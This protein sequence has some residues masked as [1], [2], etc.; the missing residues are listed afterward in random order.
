MNICVL[1]LVTEWHGVT[2]GMEVH[3]RLLTR[4][5]A[6]LGHDVTVVATGHPG[7]I[8]GETREGVRLHY[9]E[10]TRFGSQRGRWAAEC[11]A[12]VGALHA[13]RPFDVVCAQQGIVPGRLLDLCRRGGPALVALLEG[14]EALMVLSEVRQAVSHRRGVDRL[15]RALAAFAYHYL[16]WELPLLRAADR[17]IAVSDQVARS[18]RR[19]FGVPRDRL[20]VVYNGVDTAVFAPD[21]AARAATRARLGARGPL[22]LHLSALTRQK[23]VHVL[24]RALPAV[25]AA[26]PDVS[27][28]VAGDGGYAREARA[29]A[30]SLGVGHAVRFLGA[31]D[32]ADVPAYLAACDVFVLP[33]LRQEGLPFAV[34]EAMACARPVVVSRIGGVPSVVRDGDNGLLVP[35]GDE[36]ALAVAVTRAV[37]DL[38]LAERLGASA[39]AT[40]EGG[41]SAGAMV[42]GTLRSF[43]R[44]L[45][46]RR[47][48]PG[49][50][51]AR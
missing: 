24:L 49:L 11:S 30:R 51:P 5:L 44:A 20:D 22:L 48:A 9:L 10:R 12:R 27:V 8:A 23:G 41:H 45:A 37:S 40:I 17:V 32:H 38:A 35:P 34:L 50:A 43:E 16:T 33:T 36:R 1:S 3:G 26:C 4:G 47:H 18:A 19:W 13:E 6:A 14:H 15:P 39:R 21:P 46:G 25:L 31:V 28:A 29:L 42:G 7:G 2:G